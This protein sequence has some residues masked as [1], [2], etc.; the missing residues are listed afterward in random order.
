LYSVVGAPDAKPTKLGLEVTI[1]GNGTPTGQAFNLGSASG[2]F[3]KDLFLFVSEDGTISGWRGA[4]GTSAEILQTADANN[5]YKGTTFVSNGGNSYLLSANFRSGN[6]DVMKGDPASPN[7]TGNF[8]DPTL[9]AGYA[10]FNI[11]NLGG[12][13]YV[14]YAVQDGAKHDDVAAPG[15]GIV[16]EFDLNGNFI[17]RVANQGGPLNS[18]WGM[19]IAPSSWKGIAGDLL[20]G[21]FGDGHINIFDKSNN[22][23]GQLTDGVGNPLFID[24]LWALVPGNDGNAGSSQAIYFSAG[25]NGESDGLFGVIQSVPEPSSVV[26]G[27]FALGLLAARSCWKSRRRPTAA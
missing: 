6:I 16:S 1:P 25:P 14:S 27:T 26:L 18:P 4:L 20:V 8:T 7:L 9:P 24:G 10:P 15:N 17:T 19:A 5:V 12:K 21:N 11:Q 3:N 23:V 13:L 2:A 22:F